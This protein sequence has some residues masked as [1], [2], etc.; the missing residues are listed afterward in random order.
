MWCHVVSHGNVRNY[1]AVCLRLFVHEDL[2][3]PLRSNRNGVTVVADR[4]GGVVYH[5]WGEA[6]GGQA[7]GLP[8]T[9][10]NAGLHGG[11]P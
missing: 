1:V 5:I 10:K 2:V 8:N 11:D 9:A 7:G 3:F 4:R 6:A